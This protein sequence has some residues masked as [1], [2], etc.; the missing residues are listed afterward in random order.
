MSYFST[1]ICCGTQKRL[2]EA[3]LMSITTYFFFT[4][5]L[6]LSALSGAMHPFSI[7]LKSISGGYRP[8]R[9]PVR[10]I[11]VRY[12]FKK[13]ASWAVHMISLYKN[14]LFLFF[15]SPGIKYTSSFVCP[16]FN[17]SVLLIPLADC[18]LS[19]IRPC[20]L[21]RWNKA[22]SPKHVTWLQL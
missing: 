6:V 18:I 10:P 8:D 13:N 15:H 22:F 5:K 2:A 4:E 11:T 3:L 12:R 19:K 20:L 9:S 14:C 17:L 7:L 21:L 1:K 16:F